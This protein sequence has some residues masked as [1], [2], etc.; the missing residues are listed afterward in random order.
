MSTL[1]SVLKYRNDTLY[2]ALF[3][4][5]RSELH[6]LDGKSFTDNYVVAQVNPRW[7]E[8]GVFEFEPTASR[9]SWAYVT[10]GGSTPWKT[11]PGDFKPEGQSGIGT[12]LVLEAPAQSPWAIRVLQR[13]FAYQILLSHGNFRDMRPLN[14]GHRV[15]AGGPVD[16]K[17]SLVKFLAI[18]EPE[19]YAASAQLDSGKFQFLHA[20]GITESEV[21][22]AKTRSTKKLI[23]AL[24]AQRHFPVT[25][26]ARKPIKM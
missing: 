10:A 3:G 22:F 8:F 26:P 16:G 19:H 17:K 14:Y 13:L 1:E 12:E 5:T 6:A 7:L 18:A 2:P 9:K 23:A 11:E 15:P 21:E 20:I 25:E 24:K 4:E